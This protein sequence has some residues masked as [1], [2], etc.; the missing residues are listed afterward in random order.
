MVHPYKA[1]YSF[2]RNN[3]T[4]IFKNLLLSNEFSVR[5]GVIG[6]VVDID[7]YFSEKK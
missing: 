1:S 6:K 4:Q 2:G 7:E 5:I 3:G